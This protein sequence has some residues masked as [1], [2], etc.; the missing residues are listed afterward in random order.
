MKKSKLKP[1]NFNTVED[2]RLAMKDFLL[3]SVGIAHTVDTKVGDAFVRGVSGG[4]RKRVSIIETMATRGSIYCWDNPTRGLDASTALE[5][6]R[7]IRSLTDVLQLTSIMTLYQAG[8]GIYE[9]WCPI[10]PS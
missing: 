9:V 5:Y 7:A 6:T 1:S 8:N 10:R 4:E 2:F 3:R